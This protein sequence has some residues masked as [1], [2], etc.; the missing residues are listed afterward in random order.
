MGQNCG[1]LLQGYTQWHN[2]GIM[3]IRTWLYDADKEVHQNRSSII[4]M[5]PTFPHSFWT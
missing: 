4:A 3:V 1:I 2:K 5:Q